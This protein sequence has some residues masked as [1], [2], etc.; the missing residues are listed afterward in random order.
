MSVEGD[1]FRVTVKG[2]RE[3]IV[4]MMNAA[5]KSFNSDNVIADSDD[6]GTMNSKLEMFAGEEG[7]DI[8]IPDL[9]GQG[10]E[11]DSFVR[12]IEFVRIEDDSPGLAVKFSYYLGEECYYLEDLGYPA[13][14]L[15]SVTK[16][17]YIARQYD[18]T[19]FVDDDLWCNG[20][21]VR[22][23]GATIYEPVLGKIHSNHLDAG[24][25]Y[26]D[27]QYPLFLRALAYLYPDHYGADWDD[28]HSNHPEVEISEE[29]L[30]DWLD[31]DRHCSLD[32]LG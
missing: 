11:E 29:E 17:E 12:K 28:Y 24:S 8:G 15:D 26:E 2:S 6:V 31:E 18:C 20:R 13:D 25:V 27:E 3:S 7:K 21:R 32:I 14:Y 9:L 5:L 4:R 16:W 19:V 23:D 10:K 1:L 22:L 30:L